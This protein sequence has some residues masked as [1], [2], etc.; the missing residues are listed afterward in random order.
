[1]RTLPVDKTYLHSE[2]TLQET[3]KNGK[4]L[5]VDFDMLQILSNSLGK[6][7]GTILM[8]VSLVIVKVTLS[9]TIRKK[10]SII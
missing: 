10:A 6:S 9:V 3:R 2:E 7:T 5:K 4:R 1:M 8:S